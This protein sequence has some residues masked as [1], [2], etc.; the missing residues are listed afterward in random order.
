MLFPRWI[1]I[2]CRLIL[3]PRL[4]YGD[5]NAFAMSGIHED[6]AVHVYGVNYCVYEPA[7]CFEG[8]DRLPYC[9]CTG[10]IIVWNTKLTVTL[11]QD[12]MGEM[13]VRY[14]NLFQCFYVSNV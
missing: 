8:Y 6:I 9:Q 7:G 13:F 2:S 4:V 11:A 14:K 10:G 3:Y 1:K 12:R 5:A